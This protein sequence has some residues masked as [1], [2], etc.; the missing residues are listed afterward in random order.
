MSFQELAVRAHGQWD[1]L[2]PALSPDSVMEEAI[3]RGFRR[4]GPCPVHGG[5]N[6]DAFRIYENFPE[7][8]GAVCNTCGAFANGFALL[9]WLQN[10]TYAQAAKAVEDKLGGARR[11]LP[12][13][14]KR[15]RPK[16]KPKPDRG[17]P[18]SMLKKLWAEACPYRGTSAGPMRQYLAARGLAVRSADAALPHVRFHPKLLYVDGKKRTYWPGMLA[19]IIDQEGHLRGLHRTYLNP[20]SDNKAPVRAPKKVLRAKGAELVG[21]AI[22]LYRPGRVLGL[23][24]GIETAIAVQVATGMPA[25]ATT[26]GAL[27]QSAWVPSF[28]EG[29]VIWADKDRAGRDAANTAAERLRADGRK[30]EIR[31]PQDL[32]L[33][34]DW[35]DVLREHGVNGFPERYRRAG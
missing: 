2:I 23:T 32:P 10:W 17:P 7:T 26:S 5:E 21:S 28:T 33:K 4:H 15:E 35:N 29:V 1:E 8:G 13:A 20:W 19:C 16:S 9:V 34:A 14:V 25:W 12:R 31:Y 3:A 11:D 6:G 27:L 18:L 24:E 22:R 30:V